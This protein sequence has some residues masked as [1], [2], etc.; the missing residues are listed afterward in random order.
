MTTV[1]ME[2]AD[3]IPVDTHSGSSFEKDAMKFATAFIECHKD[4]LK[5]AVPATVLCWALVSFGCVIMLCINIGCWL[6]ADDD[7]PIS[8]WTGSPGGKDGPRPGTVEFVW[9]V[10]GCNLLAWALAC[11][12]AGVFK[13]ALPARRVRILARDY[14]AVA[15]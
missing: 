10:L 15:E 8:L 9:V 13:Y 11:V 6:S 14:S 5:M 3:G 1:D 4:L 12:A 7:A 2:T